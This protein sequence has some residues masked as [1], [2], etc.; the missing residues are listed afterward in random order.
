MLPVVSTFEPDP[1]SPVYLYV[2]VADHVAGLIQSGELRAGARLLAERDLA[3]EY[4]V[5]LQTA[6]RAVEE[7]RDRGLVQT[8]AVKGTFVIG[9]KH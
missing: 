8:V 7:L 9:P 6:R 2:Q 4:R 5:S 1:D 3:A